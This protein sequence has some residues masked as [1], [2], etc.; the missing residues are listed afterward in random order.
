[1]QSNRCE[2]N[3]KG[4]YENNDCENCNEEE[5]QK[6]VLSCKILNKLEKD[7]IPEYDELLKN[8]VTNQLKIA[9][10]LMKNMKIRKKLNNT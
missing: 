8:N 2:A 10:K 7:D 9:K 1:M 4:K 3:F 6:Y 5:N